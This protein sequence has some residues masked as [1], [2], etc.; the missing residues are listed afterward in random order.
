MKE[1]EKGWREKKE[2][3]EEGE[4][5]GGETGYL[6]ISFPGPG[7]HSVQLCHMSLFYQFTAHTHLYETGLI[8]L[9]VLCLERAHK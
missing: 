1:E 8:Q 7:S 3:G 9:R 2:K 6:D 4:K 5:G